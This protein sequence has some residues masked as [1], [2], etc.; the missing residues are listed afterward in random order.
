MKY[1]DKEIQDARTAL[2]SAPESKRSALTDK[3]AMEILPRAQDSNFEWVDLTDE[4]KYIIGEEVR[5]FTFI[6]TLRAA[7]Y[8]LATGN[9]LI[10]GIPSL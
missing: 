8:L 1:L 2:I 6:M 3:N 7:C 10:F 5:R 9:F 4:P